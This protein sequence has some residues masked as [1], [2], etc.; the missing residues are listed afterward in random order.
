MMRRLGDEHQAIRIDPEGEVTYHK[1]GNGKNFS[2]A[3]LQSLVGGMIERVSLPS[4]QEYLFCDENGLLKD[5]PGNFPIERK[6]RDYLT[7]LKEKDSVPWFH[8][9]H[10]VTSFPALVGPVVIVP[11]GMVL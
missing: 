5:L 4:Q 11:K 2:L 1:P 7:E 3:E 6:M 10:Y 8:L 9:L